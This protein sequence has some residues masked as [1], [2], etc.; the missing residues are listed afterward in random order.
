[1]FNPTD[2]P[3]ANRLI[4]LNEFFPDLDRLNADDRMVVTTL[5]RHSV[6][7][8]P[9][10]RMLAHVQSNPDHMRSCMLRLIRKQAIRVLDIDDQRTLIC[11]SL[12]PFSE[13]LSA[14][15]RPEEPKW[16]PIVL[17]DDL[18]GPPPAYLDYNLSAN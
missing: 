1:M 13:L 18:A 8:L 4:Q 5:I 15:Y 14:M 7:R 9:L 16:Y 6:P 12:S 10:S 3:N 2:M 11:V 17:V